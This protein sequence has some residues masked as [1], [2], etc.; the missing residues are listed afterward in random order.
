[1]NLVISITYAVLILVAGTVLSGLFSL[2]L[3]P[4]IL[5]VAM[6]F[7]NMFRSQYTGIAFAFL[8]MLYLSLGYTGFV[9]NVANM[10]VSHA[11][12]TPIWIS[13]WIV[14]VMAPLFAQLGRLN[15]EVIIGAITITLMRR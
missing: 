5:L 2:V 9:I 1:M 7:R 10:V 4:G 3:G 8:V 11:T 15:T 6:W 14:A 12:S 13:S